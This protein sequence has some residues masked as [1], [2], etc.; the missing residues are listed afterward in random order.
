MSKTAHTL[1][2]RLSAERPLIS[3]ASGLF[4]TEGSQIRSAR[5]PPPS[6]FVRFGNISEMSK[7]KQ[8]QRVLEQPKVMI[9]L[10]IIV[11]EFQIQS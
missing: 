8:N 7:S 3:Q 6:N 9:I 4:P 10:F 2:S 11:F 1:P 5:P